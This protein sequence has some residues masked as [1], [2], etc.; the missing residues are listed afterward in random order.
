MCTCVTNRKLKWHFKPLNKFPSNWREK[1]AKRFQPVAQTLSRRRY[2]ISS[3]KLHNCEL[4]NVSLESRCQDNGSK[5][6]I[7]ERKRGRKWPIYQKGLKYR[8]GFGGGQVVSV[9]AFYSNDQSSN[10]VDAYIFFQTRELYLIASFK[11]SSFWRWCQI[12][13]C[14]V[15]D[16]L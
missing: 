10:P 7:L 15:R 6:Y 9:L 8:G 5:K 16:L 1:F 2:T 11:T 14:R 4:E 13:N 12:L 3:I